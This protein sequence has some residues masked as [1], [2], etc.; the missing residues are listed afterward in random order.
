[1][2]EIVSF[3]VWRADGR[4]LKFQTYKTDI[5]FRISQMLGGYLKTRIRSD[6]IHFFNE[7]GMRLG[8]R[9]NPNFERLTYGDVVVM[10]LSDWR[11]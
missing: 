8:L 11:S 6:K 9:R 1:M 4:R 3:E 7:M 5:R 10:N 2:D